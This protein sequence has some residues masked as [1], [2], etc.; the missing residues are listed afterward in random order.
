MIPPQSSFR[1]KTTER[2]NALTNQSIEAIQAIHADWNSQG[3]LENIHQVIMRQGLAAQISGHFA[4]WV[5][6]MHML[7]HQVFQLRC[8]PYR[9]A[10][11]GE[12]F[13]QS[14]WRKNT[15]TQFN[16]LKYFE[17]DHVEEPNAKLSSAWFLGE[18]SRKW[19]SYRLEEKDEIACLQ[20][21]YVV[22]KSKIQN[23]SLRP[24]FLRWEVSKNCGEIRSW[25]APKLKR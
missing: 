5:N 19:S 21:N 10:H 6:L 14:F 17:N 23:P 1:Q 15:W 11:L 4:A 8:K 25:S 22:Q 13:M 12:N 24:G 2:S 20:L 16:I 18:I 7:S 9:L 3:N